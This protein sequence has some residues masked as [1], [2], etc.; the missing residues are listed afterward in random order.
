VGFPF[1][2]LCL[3]ALPLWVLFRL[4][5]LRTPGNRL[6]K[7]RE[8][9]LLTF[10]VYLIALATLTLTPNRSDRL[11]DDGL[12]TIELKPNPASLA[13]NSPHMQEVPNARMFC[14][15]NAVGNVLLFFPLGFLIPL[16]WARVRFWR[17]LQIALALSVG[18]ELAQYASWWWETYRAVDV[19]DV[20]LNMLGAF[21][22]LTLVNL[23]R[24]LGGNRQPAIVAS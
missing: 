3:I 17:G 12:A 4:Y 6:S 10:L 13:C 1:F 14:M 15:Q 20:F 24:L 5:R 2:V 16:I 9:L 23:L 21:L 19:N 7:R 22:G 11:R 8:F 18:I